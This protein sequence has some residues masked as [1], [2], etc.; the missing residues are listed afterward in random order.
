MEQAVSTDIANDA[1]R[2][3]NGQSANGTAGFARAVVWLLRLQAILAV[4]AAIVAGA[5][6]GMGW[7]IAA[8]AG[9]AIGIV[10]TAVSAL[11]T[12]VVS[13]SGD[14]VAMAA[15]F[16][17]GMLIKMALAVVLFVV[18]AVFFADWFVPVI[19]GY[20]V[21]LVAYWIALLRIGSQN[22]RQTDPGDAL[23]DE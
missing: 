4:A 12:G 14:P 5:V 7:A 3:G 9:G 13:A 11:R 10:L 15:A 23:N 16:Y 18:V 6:V 19:A 17:R 8:L 21:T 1:G 22:R 20:V 2:A